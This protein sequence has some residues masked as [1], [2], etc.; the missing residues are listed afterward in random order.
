MNLGVDLG[1]TNVRAGLVDHRGRVLGRASAP[2][3]AW[4]GPEA[5]AGTIAGLCREAAG[6]HWSKI[7]GGCIGAPGPLD[8]ARTEIVFA[9]NLYGWR[10]VPIARL[11]A[12]RV[13]K[14]VIL[15]NDANCAAVGEHV[16]GAGRGARSL[17][18]YT[19][20]TGV[21]GGLVLDG[22]L[23]IGSGGGAG[24]LGHT[25]VERDGRRCHCG[26]RGCL[27]AYASATA[28][29]REYRK[30]TGRTRSAKQIFAAA[31]AAARR[32]VAGAVGALVT[33][34]VNVVHALH[35]EIVILGGGV[36]A[37][38][39]KLLDPVRRGVRRL[40]FPSFRNHVRI[41]LAALGDDAGIVGAASLAKVAHG[42]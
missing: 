31:D 32:A 23:W 40:I 10:H 28:L 17:V 22:K 9:P 29:V 24:E 35:P 11:V 7:R 2:T 13:R 16:A 4:K 8:A 37:A 41:V 21:G 36:A 42:D 14:P 5:V 18:L 27:E 39:R 30:R 38:G 20:G 26:L 33:G 1:G 15:E 12:H 19:L 25:I 34:I 3:E 6:R